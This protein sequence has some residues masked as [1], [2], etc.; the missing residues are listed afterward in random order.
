MKTRY[1]L[2]LILWAIYAPHRT[3]YYY[4]RVEKCKMI[5]FVSYEQ[6]KHLTKEQYEAIMKDKI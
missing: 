2:R 6:A 3:R 5:P 4:Y 1:F